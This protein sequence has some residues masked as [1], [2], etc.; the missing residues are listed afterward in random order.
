MPFKLGYVS[1]MRARS[2]LHWLFESQGWQV[3]HSWLPSDG[4]CKVATNCTP[5]IIMEFC[6][7]GAGTGQFGFSDHEGRP[8]PVTSKS[9]APP[10][11]QVTSH[12][13]LKLLDYSN[14]HLPPGYSETF[15]NGN[16]KRLALPNQFPKCS[17]CAMSPGISAASMPRLN[18]HTS[19]SH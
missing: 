7:L 2:A 17:A 6:S 14:K 16:L 13:Q 1:N 11:I 8:L 3:S 18:L 19:H 5:T 4:H 12:I 15:M 10:K 9:R